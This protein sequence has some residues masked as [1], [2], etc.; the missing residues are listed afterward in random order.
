MANIFAVHWNEQELNALIEPLVT[1]KHNVRGHW[2]QQSNAAMKE[3]PDVLVISLDRLPSHGKAIAE[4]MWEA[5]KRQ[6][7]PIIFVGG[8]KEKLPSFKTKFPKAKFC[9]AGK[10][11]DTIEKL[12]KKLP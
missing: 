12:A 4:W 3:L 2:S 7:I 10:L 11:L 6:H 9:S 8:D 1:A 5:K